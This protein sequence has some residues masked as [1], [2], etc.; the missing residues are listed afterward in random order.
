MDSVT[1]ENKSPNNHKVNFFYRN[2][3]V[4]RILFII[5]RQNKLILLIKNVFLIRF[6]YTT[7]LRVGLNET[8]ASIIFSIRKKILMIVEN[9]PTVKLNSNRSSINVNV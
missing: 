2:L 9:K 7:Q 1:T 4:L 3:R 8:N 5:Q 6:I